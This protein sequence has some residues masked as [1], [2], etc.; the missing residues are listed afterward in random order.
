MS[1]IRFLSLLL[2]LIM[3]LGIIPMIALGEAEDDGLAVVYEDVPEEVEEVADEAPDAS[4]EAPE[5][6]IEAPAEEEEFVLGEDEELVLA[7]EEGFEAEA[8][9]AD[10]VFALMNIPYKVFYGNVLKVG[11]SD[12]IDTITSATGKKAAYFWDSSYK[13]NSPVAYGA[14]QT[15]EGVLFPVRMLKS[16]FDELSGDEYMGQSYYVV[17][18]DT[19][20]AVYAEFVGINDF[21]LKGDV[22]TLEDATVTVDRTTKHG[23]F[24]LKIENDGG[25]L[26]GA[27]KST[28]VVYGAVVTT[29]EGVDYPMYHLQNLYYKDFHEIAFSTTS[30]TNQKGMTTNKDFY[31]GLEDE[32]I[33]TITL[34]TNGG[35]YQVDTAVKVHTYSG[36][37]LMNIPYDTFLSAVGAKAD[38]DAVTA[39]TNKV[40][41]YAKAGGAW[42]S[43]QTA[44][45][46]DE[47]NV[48]AV[49]AQNDAKLEGIIWPVQISLTDVMAKGT[50][51]TDD[52]QT[53][54]ATVGRGQTSSTLLMGYETLMEAPAWSWYELSEAPTNY[55]VY[56]DDSFTEA[57]YQT[58]ESEIAVPISY[59]GH[60]AD[61][62][63][64]TSEAADISDKIINAAVMT[65]SAGQKAMVPISQVW[66]ASELGWMVDMMPE[67]SGQTI[68]N[69]RFYCSVKDTSVD[70]SEVPAY[71]NYVYDYPVDV[72]VGDLYTGEITA[73]FLD[74]ERVR[75]SGYPEDAENL[76]AYVYY[77]IDRSTVEYLAEGASVVDGV[78]ELSRVAESGITYTV[79]LESDNRVFL[80]TAAAQYNYSGYALVNIPYADFFK[81]IGADADVDAVTAATNKVGNYGKAGGAWHSAQT[82]DVDEAGNVTAVGAQNGAKLEGVIWP[83]QIA[84]SDLA[85]KDGDH[86]G[87]AS[88]A[89]VATVGRGTTSS[90]LLEGYEALMEAPAWSWYELKEA[91]DNY[92]VYEDDG[93][94][95]FIENTLFN[96]EIEVTTAYKGHHADVT[97]GTGAATAIADKII[98]A[99]VLSIPGEQ[100]AKAMVPISQVWSAS[101]IGWMLDMMPDMSGQTIN[102]IRFYCS[103]KDDSTGDGTV[104]DYVN[105]VYDYP[106]NVT[107]PTLN[108]D[109]IAAT[110]MDSE[111]VT[112][113]GY[114]EDAENLKASVYY[115]ENRTNVYLAQDVSVTTGTVELTTAAEEGKTYTVSLTS[116]NYVL[117]S[118]AEA[119]Y[120]Y[121]GYALM[122]IPYD[123]FFKVI[124]AD[125][126]IDAVTAATNK[127]GNYGKAGGAWHSAQTADVDDEGNVIAVGAQNGAK[128][129]G[130][131]WPVQISM[132]DIQS[133]KGRHI[134]D[135][136]QIAV[137]T[138]GRGTTS[139]TA[140]TGYECLMEAPAWSWYEL[141]EQP[142][143]YVVYGD[144][145]VINIVNSAEAESQIDVTVAYK[146]HHAD[147]T[148]GTGAATDIQDK[149]INAALL[150]TSEG[151]KGMVPISQIWSGS[152]IGWMA[153][154]MPEM[155]G[156]HL[157]AIRFFCSVKDDTTT[158]GEAPAYVN[159]VYEYKLDVTL[160]QLFNDAI[161][162]AFEDNSNVTVSGY[163]EDAENLK[164]SVYYT[165]NRNNVYLAENVDVVDGK[166]ALT[167]AAED[168]KAYTVALTADNY[169]ILK[170]ATATTATVILAKPG[171]T[172]AE[173]KINVYLGTSYVVK[174]EDID[175]K[176]ITASNNGKLVNFDADTGKL[177]LLKTGTAKITVKPQKG[178]SVVL[179]LKIIDPTIP[180]KITIEEGK[181]ADAVVGTP[182]TVTPVIEPSTADKT[183]TYK[184]SNLKVATVDEKGVVTLLQ[185]GSTTIKVTTSNKKT[186]SITLKVTDPKL[187]TKVTISPSKSLKAYVEN[188]DGSQIVEP[189]KL[190]AAVLPETADQTVVWTSSNEKVATIDEFGN[191]TV[192]GKGSVRFTAETQYDYGNKKASVSVSV[193]DLIN[194]TSITIK[195]SKSSLNVGDTLTLTATA[196]PK[197]AVQTVTWESDNPDVV[198]VD[199]DGNVTAVAAG[200]ATI[201]A[202]SIQNQKTKTVKIKVK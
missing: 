95:S 186:A 28:F 4:P 89:L 192:V 194:P 96:N 110:F 202:T 171:M 17:A 166:I 145:G 153:D 10:Y 47:G 92:L 196:A 70:D 122:N 136:D 54:V 77:N 30:E 16:T 88:K 111:H 76:V 79:R 34:W 23:D 182:F 143:N 58:D 18:L 170:N 139:V 102:N 86:L 50:E 60:H 185:K 14:D 140:L 113:S 158:D 195:G 53:L 38:I 100:D 57:T 161:T 20:P 134:S 119:T 37:A 39:A 201:T 108:T 118:N 31:A 94:L 90:T 138:V 3:V 41:N 93:S 35:I 106:V 159:Y 7:E 22:Q 75:V 169:V 29:S 44:D 65:T 1:R 120:T 179:T 154:M 150:T 8:D 146:G 48:I 147:V 132:E 26:T 2:T 124:G 85:G 42:H 189:L 162:A 87:D 133:L 56:A 78:V 45:A 123:D 72:T 91:P 130:V 27:D 105:Y 180:T 172:S 80:K 164:A 84:L 98:N 13:G 6:A 46:D 175:V 193:K 107:L 64:T 5:E 24:M 141:D 129:E 121:S 63:L 81:G 187:P 40:G 183:V 61:V 68:S 125:A 176:S 198:S 163:P 157:T 51:V 156:K 62:T 115:T 32:T 184:S 131:I 167:T 36:Y 33:S 15:I 52:S 103:V 174:T 181:K 200:T 127:V 190:S 199:A 59:G 137:A 101:E 177:E 83:V 99:V 66:S 82:A 128:L 21:T 11:N 73:E 9:D 97:L 67:M 112:V 74:S 142:T 109:A 197:T 117:F 12:E 165:E 149:I 168:E 19:A 55:L 71:A 144:G 49:G 160:D 191:V 104:P 69:I 43:A 25:V 152:E 116:D 173:K 155:S 126:D 178:S 148:L 188:Y 135:V 114:P 151:D